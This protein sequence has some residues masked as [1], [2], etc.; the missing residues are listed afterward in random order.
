MRCNSCGLEICGSCQV[1]CDVCQDGTYCGPCLD[2]NDA[3]CVE[4]QE[5]DESDYF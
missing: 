3:K 1:S 4:C 5:N 2:A